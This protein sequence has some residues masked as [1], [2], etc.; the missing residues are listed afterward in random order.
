MKATVNGIQVEGTPK[1]LHEF[2]ELA[3]APLVVKDIKPIT[4]WRGNVNN[5]NWR[6]ELENEGLSIKS[7]AVEP[8]DKEKHG[9]YV[10]KMRSKL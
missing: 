9:D 1:E 4:E 8:Y 3:N 2:V 7:C 10:K 6:V 5:L